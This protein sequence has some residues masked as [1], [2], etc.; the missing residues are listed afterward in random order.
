MTIGVASVALVR[1]MLDRTFLLGRDLDEDEEVGERPVW[2]ARDMDR[3]SPHA[4]WVN[5]SSILPHPEDTQE[6]PRLDLHDATHIFDER[7]L[8]RGRHSAEAGE[9]R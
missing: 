5:G 2:T 8:H 1:S 4:A 3:L 6:M 9:R 7:Y